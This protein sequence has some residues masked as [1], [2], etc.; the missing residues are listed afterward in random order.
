MPEENESSDLEGIKDSGETDSVLSIPPQTPFFRAVNLARYRRQEQI[1]AIQEY[2]HHRL[3]CYVSESAPLVREDVVPFMDL[4]HQVPVGTDIDFLLNT[5]GGDVGTADKIARILRRRVGSTGKFRVLVPDFAKSAGTLLALGAD[6]IVMSDSSEL[7]PIDPQIITRQPDGQ[8]VQRP[9]HTYVDS[10]DALVAKISNP[11]SYENGKNADAEK[12]LL[13]GF[14]PA[15]LNLCRQLI[16]RSRQ[17]AEAL[18]KQGMLQDGSYTKAAGDLTDNDRWHSDH[19]AVI[20]SQ[21][22][23][24]IGLH[25]DYMEPNCNEWQ[26]YWR[27]YCEQRLVLDQDHTKLFESDLASLS[28]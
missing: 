15:K 10:Y 16:A 4:L 12:L 23:Q 13:E 1:K 2:T 20:D 9:A 17:L 7:G 21:D 22:A 3:I 27:L 14:D 5:P 6:T 24:A 11:K 28:F 18:L 25:V 19:G 8:F 26:A